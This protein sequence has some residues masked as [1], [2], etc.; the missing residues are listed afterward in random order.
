MN[1]TSVIEGNAVEK[2]LQSTLRY[3]VSN[4]GGKLVKKNIEDGRE[5]QIEAGK[6]LTTDYCV[7]VKK[8]WE[9]YDVN[10]KFYLDKIYREIEILIPPKSA[11]LKL[12]L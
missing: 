5:I 12:N 9:E 1:E 8:P 4:K 2:T 6:W 3:Y 10:E 11:Q 7:A